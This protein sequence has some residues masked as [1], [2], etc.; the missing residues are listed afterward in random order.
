M[1]IGIELD[2][3]IENLIKAWLKEH[4]DGIFQTIIMGDIVRKFKDIHRSLHSIKSCV[5]VPFV[6]ESRIS[7]VALA[8]RTR[9]DDF[10]ESLAY[11][12]SL[13]IP[14]PTGFLTR[15]KL[16]GIVSFGFEA[17]NVVDNFETV[18]EKAFQAR[19]T[20]FT[21]DKI[22]RT[23]REKYYDRIT[24]IIKKVLEKYLEEEINKIKENISTFRK[25]K[26]VLKSKEKTLFSLQ[27]TVQQ[28]IDRLYQI[29]CI[30]TSNE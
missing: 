16:S 22:Q 25:N 13:H 17:F 29:I 4:I 9:V 5:K 12:K 10:L 15:G 28:N 30:N 6:L 18:R 3:R 20:A 24:T 21:K 26:G 1:T 14:C 19:I 7:P 23:L 8:E 2:V 11:D 27:S